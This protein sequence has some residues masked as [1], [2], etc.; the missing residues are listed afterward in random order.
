MLAR[1]LDGDKLRTTTSSADIRKALADK[2]RIWIDLERKS[3]EAEA[4]LEQVLKLHALTIEDI[5]GPVSQPK[6]DD[7]DE[8]LYVIVHGI[9]AAN[10]DRLELVEIDIVI[11]DNWLV[12]HDRD[13]LVS[14]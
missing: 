7:F 1:I 14:D 4:L 11:G 8:Y 2:Q 5:W 9:G 3:P 6:I 13:G 12:T 10:K